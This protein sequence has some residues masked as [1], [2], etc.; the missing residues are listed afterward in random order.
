MWRRRDQRLPGPTLDSRAIGPLPGA[1]PAPLRITIQGTVL[2]DGLRIGCE[3]MTTI[4]PGKNLTKGDCDLCG[5][6]SG[7]LKE[8]ACR[9]CRTRWRL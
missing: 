3:G 9:P 7:D 1:G 4:D 6:W 2:R 8:G 5:R